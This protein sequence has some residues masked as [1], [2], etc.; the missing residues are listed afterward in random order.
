MIIS[1]ILTRH[2]WERGRERKLLAHKNCFK[3]PA[4]VDV[5]TYSNPNLY[6][7]FYKLTEHLK[8]SSSRVVKRFPIATWAPI[9]D[10]KQACC[11]AYYQN[12]FGCCKHEAVFF[13]PELLRIHTDLRLDQ[14]EW[15]TVLQLTIHKSAVIDTTKEK[16]IKHDKICNL[17]TQALVE[18][19]D[20]RIFAAR[21]RKA[22]LY[23]LEQKM[24]AHRRFQPSL[25]DG[26]LFG[27][28]CTI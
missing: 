21:H 1:S 15:S 26:Y 25:S 6:Q 18:F 16:A 19:L 22:C 2:W 3:P 4:N 8:W 28:H 13:L 7:H 23:H 5:L 24:I 12:F 14:R 10:L 27:S 9:T 20:G 17:G 11:Q